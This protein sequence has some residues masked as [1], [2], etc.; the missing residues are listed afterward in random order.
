[1]INEKIS[2]MTLNKKQNKRIN[3]LNIKGLQNNMFHNILANHSPI[4]LPCEQSFEPF[5][6]YPVLFGQ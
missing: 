1:M 6:Q 3:K 2:A 5:A 4:Y